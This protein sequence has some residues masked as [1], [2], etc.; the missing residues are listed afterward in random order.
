[1]R[2]GSWNLLAQNRS[3]GGSGLSLSK[4]VR[5]G[6]PPIPGPSSWRIQ[7]SPAMPGSGAGLHTSPCCPHTERSS[8]LGQERGRADCISRDTSVGEHI[9]LD[10]MCAGGSLSLLHPE[11]VLWVCGYGKHLVT[12]PWLLCGSFLQQSEALEFGANPSPH[13]TL[14]FLLHNGSGAVSTEPRLIGVKHLGSCVIQVCTT[15]VILL[16]VMHN[17]TENPL[18]EKF[19]LLSPSS[20][21]QIF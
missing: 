3:Q 2:N 12:S 14:F 4:A 8:C 5:T 11:G 9:H 19:F 17:P 1:M 13:C 21:T 6:C 18:Q 10:L 7:A 16:R 15:S 20:Q